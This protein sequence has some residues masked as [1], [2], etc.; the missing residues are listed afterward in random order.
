[1]H[2]RERGPKYPIVLK[3][4]REKW[5]NLSVYFKYPT[6]IRKVIYTT[7]TIEAVHHQFR[8]LTKTK[9]AFPNENSLLKLLYMG[10]QNASKKW[11]MPLQNWN[12][13]LSQLSIYFE[14]SVLR[15]EIFQMQRRDRNDRYIHA[16][17]FVAHQFYRCQDNMIDL[18]FSVMASFKSAAVREYQET[19]AQERKDQQRQIAVVIDGLE[20]SVFG[21]LDGIESVMGEANLSDAEKVAAAKALLAQ[22]K[23][24]DFKQLKDD[25]EN[26]AKN[27]SWYDILESRSLR[28]Q[29]RLSAVLRALNFMPTERATALQIAINHI[30][31]DGDLSASHTPMG[32]LD[33]EQKAALIREDGTFRVSLYKVFLF[34]AVTTAIKS[35]H[36]NVGTSYKYRPMDAYL[37]DKAHW[38]REKAHLLERAGL[39]EF[40]DPDSIL[41]KLNSALYVQYQATNDRTGGNL[42]LKLRKDETFHIATPAVDVR[43]TDPHGDLFPQRRDVP[44]AQV[45]ETSPS[46]SPLTAA[47]TA[48]FSPCSGICAA[49]PSRRYYYPKI[50]AKSWP[51]KLS[52]TMPPSSAPAPARPL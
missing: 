26:T 10:I 19:L 21:V 15:S 14:S 6:D 20:V 34:Q 3:S 35:G 39:T 1:M 45:P 32:F 52:K 23:T 33:A 42:H 47:R 12:L 48:P 41:A 29:N 25:L 37:I 36:L 2:R 31:T 40:A 8:K 28:L 11:T 5:P 43:D 24:R 18:W 38:R 16:A 50:C 22:R 51:A 46:S 17:A 7:N 44:L 4:W 9:G 30:K 27:L 13:T 49:A